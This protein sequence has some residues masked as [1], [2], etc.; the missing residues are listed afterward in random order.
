MS[1]HQLDIEVKVQMLD[2]ARMFPLKAL[3]DS[4]STGSCISREFMNDNKIWTRKTTIPV[5]CLGRNK[6]L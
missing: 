2:D 1:G 5:I 3:L 4:G 6:D